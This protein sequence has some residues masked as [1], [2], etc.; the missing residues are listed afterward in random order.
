MAAEH[1][2]ATVRGMDPRERR[3]F[4]EQVHSR[5]VRFDD[6]RADWASYPETRLPQYARGLR[7][8]VGAGSEKAR[9]DGTRVESENFTLAVVE[10]PPGSGAALHAHTTEE[11]FMPLRGE[12]VVYWGPDEEGVPQHEVRLRTWDTISLPGPVM[13]GFRN[14]S[15]EQG[16]LLITTGGPTTPV[17]H[18][19][20]VLEQV[21]S[22]GT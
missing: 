21:R 11:V 16:F 6:L 7:M 8:L 22:M 19:E 5:V 14:A 18:H 17:I 20:L 13:R 2:E 12:W 15:H 10:A 4:D 1:D 3:V 9:P